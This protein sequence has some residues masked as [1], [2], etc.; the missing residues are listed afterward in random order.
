MD[1]NSQISSVLV[2][3]SEIPGVVTLID[4]EI[5]EEDSIDPERLCV[6]EQLWCFPAERSDRKVVEPEFNISAGQSE[7]G[8][9]D[10][11][12]AEGDTRTSNGYRSEK[13]TSI[14]AGSLFSFV[15][16]CAVTQPVI[17]NGH[18]QANAR[19]ALEQWRRSTSC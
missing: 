11:G 18:D 6:V 14:H 2:N 13:M 9:G 19:V 15:R 12:R 17:A 10:S 3:F 1:L 16:M 8:S 5:R 7:G 4:V